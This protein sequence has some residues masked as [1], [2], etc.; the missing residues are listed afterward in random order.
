MNRHFRSLFSLLMALCI[1]LSMCPAVSAAANPFRDVAATDW[2]YSSVLWA[3]NHGVTD[4]K[5]ANTF[6]PNEGCTRAQVV[7][8][9]WA[10]NG[11]PEILAVTSPFTDVSP[12]DW[13]F[14]PVLWAVK[15]GITKGISD[16]EFGPEQTCTRA[17][18]VTFLYAAK[19]RPTVSGSSSFSD[20]ADT[21][22]YAKPVIWAVKKEVTKGIGD[23][24]FGPNDTCT[25][26]QVV[27]FLC[28]V[29]GQNTGHIP[30]PSLKPIP[31]PT[32][33]PSA[34]PVP[35]PITPKPV[36]MATP[37]PTTAPEASALNVHFIDVGQADAALVECDGQ[38]MLI[39]GG[40]KADSSKIYSVLKSAKVPKLDILVATHAHEDH[41]GGLAGALNYTKADLILSPVTDYDSEAFR[42]FRKYADL[43]G[44]ITIPKAGDTYEL[45]SATVT[46]LGLNLA[47]GSNN[48]SIVLRIDHGANSFLFMGD[49]ERDAEL[50]LTESGA[51]LSADVLKVGHHGSDTS[52]TYPLLYY[53]QPKYAVISVGEDK[54]YGH[55]TEVVLSRLRDADVKLYRTDMQGDIHCISNGEALTFTVTRSEDADVFGGIGSNSTQPTP[56]PV[57]DMVWIP[58]SG[59]KYHTVPDCSGMKNPTQVTLELAIARGYSAC[60]KCD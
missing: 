27:T 49:A 52:T 5:T 25:R 51:K 13:F 18:I 56:S 42:D 57:V 20:V 41:V 34:I 10:A 29:Y 46:I 32:P 24:K 48:T 21:D 15:Q 30:L 1:L 4:G 8:F 9:L 45:G 54:S 35:V 26:A 47:Q 12:S 50:A 3:V 58:T 14:K 60:T 6:A 59:S 39:D 33:V 16:T 36:P 40:N 37:T 44:G 7:T 43:S 11:K 31:I 2:F 23:G 53:A 55:P 19:G 28:K 38:Y 17:Q 22:W